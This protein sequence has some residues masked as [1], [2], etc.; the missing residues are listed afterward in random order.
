VEDA[1]VTHEPSA[2]RED[3]PDPERRALTRRGLHLEYATIGWNAFEGIAA[4][5]AGIVAHSV[6][7]T[8]FGLDSAVEVFASSVAAWQLRAE[9]RHRDRRALRLI[10]LC[11]LLVG[12]YVGVQSIV[13]L[14][15]GARPSGSPFGVAI[16]AAAV[17]VMSGLGVAKRSVAG[18]LGNPVLG[19]EARFSLVDAGLSATV[20]LGLLLNLTL[21]WWW[22]DPASALAIAGLALVEAIEGLR[23]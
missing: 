3:L 13:H 18:A 22:A 15:T 16:T 1:T 6:A 12:I 4:I 20:L 21:G 8:A 7:L 23:A 9:G 2:I 5:A 17:V 10:G 19:A 11:F 14:V